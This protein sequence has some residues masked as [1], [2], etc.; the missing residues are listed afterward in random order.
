[1]S[2]TLELV[3]KST[4]VE[5][6]APSTS[7]R[8]RFVLSTETPDLAGD[9]V[10]QAGRENASA[11]IPAQ[12]DHSGAIR[13]LVGHWEN[14]KTEGKRTTGELV[15]VDK[16]ISRTADLVRALLDAGVRMAASI[17]FQSVKR[18]L[19]R[20]PDTDDGRFVGYRFQR[21]K[22]LEASVVV[23]PANPEALSFAKSHL[24]PEHARALDLL[25]NGRAAD[26]DPSRL[27][28]SRPALV[29]PKGKAMTTVADRIA[30][31]EARVAEIRAR[32]K[33]LS[34]QD[35][36]DSQREELDALDAELAPLVKDVDA[37]KKLEAGLV[38]RA[39]PANS[40]SLVVRQTSPKHK[41]NA[42]LFVRSALCAFE[43]Y[44]KR[45]PVENIVEQRYKGDEAT[46]WT[47]A[48]TTKAA[49]N[50]AMTNVPGWAQELVRET[51][52]AFMD[53]LRPESVV[54][55][56]PLARYSF[57]GFGSIKIPM[58][59]GKTPNLSGA[60]RAE[61]APIRVGALSL[62]SATLTPKSMG[63]IGTYTNELFE[64]STPNIEQVIREAM[65][66]DTAETL[67]AKFLSAD[68]ATATAPAGIQNGIGAGNTAASTGT[69]AANILAD[70]RGRLQ[71]M[72][73]AGMGRRPVWVMNPARAWGLGLA[74]TAAGTYV[75]P[76]MSSSGVLLGV[77]VVTSTT[78][79]ADIVYLIDGAEVAFVGGAPR[80]LGTDVATLH[81]E[82]DPAAVAPIVGASA[83]AIAFP[84]RSLFQTNSSAL[85]S[86]WEV[87]WKVLR[88]GQGAVQTIT[89]VAW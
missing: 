49:Q 65:L 70:L 9:V 13:D 62:T 3:R 48:L 81:E 73:A 12:V 7:G 40:G 46:R 31:K 83:A 2:A 59:N 74:T 22:L 25:V 30:S 60:F 14:I 37:L 27:T 21:W 78:V 8:H 42:D 4:T 26:L 57:D 43:A 68:A 39:T 28:V 82:S 69:T 11:R 35:F 61:G 5:L 53:L 76:E 64:R 86:L 45:V 52:G 84:V 56:I 33:E 24:T 67:D 1:M 54:P 72:A 17:G 10:V 79:P 34:E 77:P 66:A 80:F 32:F 41:P 88:V 6:S 47:V 89:A 58:R 18:D 23:V 55:R 19:I 20:E 71:A 29:N 85:R 63:V 15:L 44:I 75:F 16:G 51:F 36:D 87:D 50:P 38:E